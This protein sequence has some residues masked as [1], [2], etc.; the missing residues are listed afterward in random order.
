MTPSIA[1]VTVCG[2]DVYRIQV[3]SLNVSMTIERQKVH[4]LQ[5]QG[6]WIRSI[7]SP[8]DLLRSPFIIFGVRLAIYLGYSTLPPLSRFRCLEIF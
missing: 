3:N 4:S 6:P 8:M 2:T 7:D 5:A 1:S